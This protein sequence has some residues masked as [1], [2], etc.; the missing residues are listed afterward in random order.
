[1]NPITALRDGHRRRAAHSQSMA[2]CAVKSHLH[3]APAAP[4]AGTCL[5]LDHAVG[6][7]RFPQATINERFCGDA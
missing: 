2:R 3:T 6:A 4:V 7:A 5:A 1:M